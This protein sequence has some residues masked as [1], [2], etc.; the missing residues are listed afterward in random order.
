[1]RSSRQQ[2]RTELAASYYD[3][4]LLDRRATC[5]RLC[6]FAW[7]AVWAS[8][9]APVFR[10]SPYAIRMKRYMVE[11]GG[12]PGEGSST[13]PRCKTLVMLPTWPQ[14]GESRVRVCA[15]AGPDPWAQPP[16]WVAA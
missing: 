3:K 5:E 9:H 15:V 6:R 13:D 7:A 14:I 1:M 16:D 12:G 10:A 4:H 8:P 2:S 11:E